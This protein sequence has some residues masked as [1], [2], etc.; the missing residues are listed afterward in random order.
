MAT[1]QPPISILQDKLSTAFILLNGDTKNTHSLLSQKKRNFKAPFF[2]ILK[3]N[4]EEVLNGE[5]IGLQTLRAIFNPKN[6]YYPKNKYGNVIKFY[7]K[8]VS[9]IGVNYVISFNKG[10]WDHYKNQTPAKNQLLKY[11]SNNNSSHKILPQ[12][13]AHSYH[14]ERNDIIRIERE[15]PQ[16]IRTILQFN[17][18][19]KNSSVYLIDSEGGTGKSSF[20]FQV[21]FQHH[22]E[23]NTL[24]IRDYNQEMTFPLAKGRHSLVLMDDASSLLDNKKSV[25]FFLDALY[26]KYQEMG[27]T[28]LLFERTSLIENKHRKTLESL[29]EY[30]YSS[31]EFA[32]FTLDKVILPQILEKVILELEV[33]ERHHS[34]VKYHFL[35]DKNV[36]LVE[37]I[38]AIL[39]HLKYLDITNFDFKF[40]WDD[41]S[42]FCDKSINLFELKSLYQTL[43]ILNSVEVYPQINFCLEYF[44]SNLSS[45][46]LSLLLNEDLPIVKTVDGTL[47]VRNVNTIEYYFDQ[48][49]ISQESIKTVLEEIIEYCLT[50]PFSSAKVHLLRNIY[51]NKFIENNDVYKSVLPSNQSVIK[52]FKQFVKENIYG[53]DAS[54]TLMEL[55]QLYSREEKHEKAKKQLGIII[56]RFPNDCLHAETKRVKNLIYKRNFDTAFNE[57]EDLKSKYPTNLYVLNLYIDCLLRKKGITSLEKY[58]EYSI[59][60]KRAKSSEDLAL[61]LNKAI[62]FKSF[63]TYSKEISFFYKDLIEKSREKP[64]IWRFKVQYAKFLFFNKYSENQL[65]IL[66]KDILENCNSPHIVCHFANHLITLGGYAIAEQ[67]IR[68]S[69]QKSD[70]HVLGL[71]SVLAT[72]LDKRIGDLHNI[73]DKSKILL[74]SK[75]IVALLSKNIELDSQNIYSIHQLYHHYIKLSRSGFN[76]FNLAIQELKKAFKIDSRS[77]YIIDGTLFYLISTFQYHKAITYSIKFT[78]PHQKSTAYLYYLNNIKSLYS[79]DSDDFKTY[80]KESHTNNF[81]TKPF[82]KSKYDRCENT[83]VSSFNVG[84]LDNEFVYLPADEIRYPIRNSDRKIS[85]EIDV[86]SSNLLKVF[87]V[88]QNHNGQL[89][90]NCI[91]PYYDEIPKSQRDLYDWVWGKFV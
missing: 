5:T 66:I 19:L 1:I 78:S 59:I 88:L 28:I 26:N 71:N 51:R 30:T 83:Y 21:G 76:C 15:G 39:K 90:A 2:E 58:A 7:D 73:K 67:L 52:T 74:I 75:E 80:I 40:D 81:I 18:N 70:V 6:G 46:A 61:F 65:E 4:I 63:S 43:S 45:D 8:V 12:V 3:S 31:I 24:L 82:K 35:S 27:V 68:N 64:N 9:N 47:A 33:E 38:C 36:T 85:K 57:L 20:I 72:I 11:Y 60:L 41:W 77:I 34:A 14:I 53:S 55:Y 17:R 49:N 86:K 56:K 89:L 62:S 32:S 69:L 44:Q 22:E 25:K 13:I 16:S 37:R 50:A 48:N 84:Y 10:Y 29:G 54:K 42:L 23:Y 91:E 79:M 87:F